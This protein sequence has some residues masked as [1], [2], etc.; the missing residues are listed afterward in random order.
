MKEKSKYILRNQKD[1]VRVYNRG[2]SKGSRYTVIL[3]RKNNL[4]FTRI[5]FVSSKKVGNSVKRN[6]ARRL[7]RE[8]YRS[9]SDSLLSGYDI[10][11]VARNTINECKEQDVHKSILKAVRSCGLI[12]DKTSGTEK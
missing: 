1:F 3:Y 12:Q 11:F 4:G 8:S 6:R 10:I 5:A 2:K 7:M 9:F